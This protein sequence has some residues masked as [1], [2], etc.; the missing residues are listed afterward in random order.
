LAKYLEFEYLKISPGFRSEE[1]VRQATARRYKQKGQGLVRVE[2][3]GDYCKRTRQHSPDALDSLS[4][5]VFLLRQRGGA[6]ATMNDAKPELPQRTKA[7]QGIE[8]MEYVDFS[9]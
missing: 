6:I 1:L 3:K 8:K 5:L 4:L 7:L 2:S 9:E